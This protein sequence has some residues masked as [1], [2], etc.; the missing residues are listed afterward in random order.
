MFK[1]ST[2]GPTGYA[3]TFANGNTLSVQ[4]GPINYCEKRYRHDEYEKSIKSKDDPETYGSE[5]QWWRSKNC[6]VL[7][8]DKDGNEH[9]FTGERVEGW[10]TPERLAE[11]MM[12]VSTNTLD[13]EGERFKDV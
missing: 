9:Y 8:F 4:W 1:V 3:I 10:V 2:H 12:W 5:L 7:A 6:E 13:I 11:I